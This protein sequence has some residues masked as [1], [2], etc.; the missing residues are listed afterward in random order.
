MKHLK[1]FVNLKTLGYAK[2]V[3]LPVTIICGLCIITLTSGN[4]VPA[5]PAFESPY[6]F[7]NR[8]LKDSIQLLRFENKIV[9]ENLKRA[10]EQVTSDTSGKDTLTK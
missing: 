4:A 3:K 8:R 10:V 7:E 6:D 2:A 1:S 5:K 9:L